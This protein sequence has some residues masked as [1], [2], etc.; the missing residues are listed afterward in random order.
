MRNREEELGKRANAHVASHMQE[1]LDAA[2]LEWSDQVRSRLPGAG[3]PARN[4]SGNGSSPP[5][6]AGPASDQKGRVL[7]GLGKYLIIAA[8]VN[9]ISR[10]RG[11]GG[12]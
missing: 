8:I 3:G 10:H 4:A 11:R 6:E 9:V 1:I 12:R 2:L 5:P 7:A